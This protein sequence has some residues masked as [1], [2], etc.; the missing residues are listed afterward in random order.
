MRL[1]LFRRDPTDRRPFSKNRIEALSDGIFAIAMTLLVLDL[2][3]PTDTAPGQLGAGLMHELPELITF[4]ITFALA[5]L[6]WSMQH[7]V[8]ELLDHVGQANLTLTFLFLGFVSILPFSTSLWGHHL[9]DP[10]AFRIYYMNQF[11]L[12]ALLTAKVEGARRK[13]HLRRG[14]DSISLR[15]R[16][17]GMSVAMG[18]TAV[19][20]WYLP[21][22]LYWVVGYVVVLVVLPIRVL[23]KRMVARM[24]AAESHADTT[25]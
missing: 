22:R 5:A 6:F 10:V 9:K 12:A 1:R 24:L 15:L 16:L 25:V 3:V 8:L 14:I 19:C 23:R 20:V 18:T 4:V 2:K 11:A 21:L 13:G 7:R 17:Y